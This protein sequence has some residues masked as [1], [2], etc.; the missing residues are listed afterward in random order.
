MSS[1]PLVSIITPVFNSDRYLDECIKSVF[2]QS[3]EHW[4]L[5]LVDDGSTDDSR[6][7]CEGWVEKDSR[8]KFYTHEGNANRGVSATRNLAISKA[9]G[10]LV[11][12]LDS[13]DQWLPNKLQ[14]Q[15]EVFKQYDDVII[16]Y[17]KS[18]TVD[19]NGE[20]YAPISFPAILGKAPCSGYNKYVFEDMI[21]LR[22]SMPCLTVMCKLGEVRAIGG[23]NESFVMQVEDH[24]LFTLLSL[25]HPVFFMD[26]IIAKYRM[27]PSSYT[28]NNNWKFSFFEYYQQLYRYCPKTMNGIIKRAEY[29]FASKYFSVLCIKDLTNQLTKLVFNGAI[30]VSLAF[31][32]IGQR[33]T[34]KCGLGA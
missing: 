10:G 11:A 6:A 24:Y 27:H 30:N 3:Y 15:V 4:E 13:D 7:I 1:D 2:S 19:E 22:M 5:I 12:F 26:E 17:G 32:L 31:R 34:K 14:K 21:F 29:E 8:V 20:T 23:F 18:V 9:S 16:V 28:S 25:N 33:V